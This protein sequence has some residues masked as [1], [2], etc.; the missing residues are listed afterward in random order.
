MWWKKYCRQP[1]VVVAAD[2]VVVNIVVAIVDIVVIVVVADVFV[3]ELVVIV[4]V[5]TRHF[6]CCH[7]RCQ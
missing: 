5:A 7:R 6:S 4:K 3:V 2:I 1:S